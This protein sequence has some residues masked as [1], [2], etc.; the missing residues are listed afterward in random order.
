MN[1]NLTGM[2][3][4]GAGMWLQSRRLGLE[5]VSRHIKASVWSLTDWQMPRSQSWNQESW[6]W[7]RSRTVRPRA[8]PWCGGP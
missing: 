6:S 3:H 2:V 7:Y 8:H 5:A 1:S 4:C